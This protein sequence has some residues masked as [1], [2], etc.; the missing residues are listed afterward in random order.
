MLWLDLSPTDLSLLLSVPHRAE[1]NSSWLLLDLT[2]P[3]WLSILGKSVSLLTFF[4]LLSER[5]VP[6]FSCD[7]VFV[8]V[9]EW[10]HTFP[11][12]WLASAWHVFFYP[13]HSLFLCFCLCSQVHGWTSLFSHS[14]TI[15]FRSVSDPFKL[16]I[17]RV[18]FR[19][20]LL[21]S[22]FCLS[23]LFHIPLVVLTCLALD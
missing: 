18:G 3:S 13:F 22:V 23:H 17:D 5:C 9:W 1:K 7:C 2:R 16:T 12:S 10:L 21:P 11:L 19:S 15:I 20:I 4:L 6:V 14:V 8:Q